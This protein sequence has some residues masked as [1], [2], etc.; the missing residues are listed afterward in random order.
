MAYDSATGNLTRRVDATQGS[1]QKMHTTRADLQ[2]NVVLAV[3][4]RDP[5]RRRYE[6]Y[7]LLRTD[8]MRCKNV[9]GF[10]I[11]IRSTALST[12]VNRLRLR[13]RPAYPA[14]ELCG[15][16]AGRAVPDR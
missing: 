14:G 15:L 8:M 11:Y 6:N 3:L 13:Q 16:R 7:D 9:K 10:N 5:D 4:Q 2:G 12:S 1:T